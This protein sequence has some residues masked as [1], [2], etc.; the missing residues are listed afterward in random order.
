M[1]TLGWSL[2]KRIPIVA[3]PP[4]FILPKRRKGVERVVRPGESSRITITSDGLAGMSFDVIVLDI[5][6]R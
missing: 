4:T 1:S 3:R 2:D 5:D 6:A